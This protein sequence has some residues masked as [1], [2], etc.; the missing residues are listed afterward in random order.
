MIPS[1]EHAS[2]E[3]AR[4]AKDARFDGLF[5]TA[6]KTTR[7]YCRPI[8][9]AV[10]PKEQNVLYFKSAIEAASAGFR[11]CLR[12]HPD[13]APYSN[14]WQGTQTSFQRALGL[15]NQGALQTGNL[16]QLADRL[17]ITDRY[18]RQL[19]NQYLGVSPKSYAL[20]QQ[21]LFAKQLLHQSSLSITEIAMAVGFNSLRRFNDCFKKLITIT[22]SQVR[23]ANEAIMNDD[24]TLKL[25][26]RPPFCWQQLYQFL[27]KRQIN[28]LEW[29]YD[30]T[31]GR[32]IE[33]ESTTGYFEIS[34]QPNQHYLTLKLHVNRCHDLNI[35][36]NRI[37]RLFDLDANSLAIDRQLQP[38]FSGSL[39]YQPGLRLPGIWSLFEAGV[40]A[41]LG[42][43]VSIKAAA[44][45][46]ASL[47][48]N[49][50]SQLDQ[51]KKLFPSPQAIATSDLTFLGTPQSRKDTLIRFSQWY[52][53]SA[54]PEDI[55]QWLSIKGIGP[56]TADYAKMRGLGDPD[57]WLGSDLGVKKVLAETDQ[58]L[59]S[60]KASPWRSYLTLQL[61]NQ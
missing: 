50:G 25:F 46:I 18:L 57:V 30:N 32:S 28:Q 33:Y 4:L 40:R 59:Q 12:C 6:V 58:N 45:L 3:K 11:P 53:Q 24:L 44:D 7:I 17:G 31:Y 9:P 55:S 48:L 22:P 29:C 54:N 39:N 15:I 8:C 10:P 13:S 1:K 27:Q 36:V 38:L 35:L 16:Q 61:W 49:L 37:R 19:F 14:R 43:Q 52:Q 5:F 21:C 41:I 23:R 56:W 20:Y 60:D 51:H 34:A 47:V 26:Y 42:Q 2:Y